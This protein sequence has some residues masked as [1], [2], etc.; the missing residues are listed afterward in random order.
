MSNPWAK[1]KRSRKVKGTEVD[2]GSRA[3]CHLLST[4]GQGRAGQAS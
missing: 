1:A 2:Q 4:M 3:T